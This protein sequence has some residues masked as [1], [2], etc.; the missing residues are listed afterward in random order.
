MRIWK[1]QLNLTDEQTVMMPTGAKLLDVQ[2]QGETTGGA[3]CLWAMCDENAPK[4]PRRI[5]IYGTGNLMPDEP[6]EYI[7]TFQVHGGALVFHAFELRA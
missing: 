1:W 5:A 3:C 6:G 7:A 4:E 2:M